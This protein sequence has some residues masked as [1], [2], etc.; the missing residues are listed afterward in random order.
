MIEFSALIKYNIIGY[1]RDIKSVIVRLLEVIM[2]TLIMGFALKDNFVAGNRTLEKFKVGVVIED[3]GKV[4][5][6]FL[7]Y[8]DNSD[9]KD[10]IEL[11]TF[12][13]M[14][15]AKQQLGRS[16]IKNII[17]ITDNYS[18]N[19]L[20]EIK[21]ITERERSYY[22]N[23]VNQLIC[24]FNKYEEMNLIENKVT[25]TNIG[26]I[27][28]LDIK[29]VTA[30]GRVPKSMDFYG[31]TMLV[32]F[33]LSS[34]RQG[35][36]AYSRVKKTPLGERKRIAPI[37]RGIDILASIVA[38]FILGTFEWVL[39]VVL[40]KYSLGVNYGNN[41]FVF[42]GLCS[43][44]SI[45]SIF[46]GII[47]GEIVGNYG[48]AQSILQLFVYMSTFLAGGFSGGSVINSANALVNKICSM[49]PNVF[50]HSILFSYIYLGDKGV[51]I[52]SLWSMVM[53]IVALTLI[54]VLVRKRRRE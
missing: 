11:I 37:N 49:L 47:V 2:I 33:I 29:H 30:T 44:L 12:S 19:I 6:E 52:N 34:S 18:Y 48:K 35:C 26:K 5:G 13:N 3:K 24:S 42:M 21:L 36:R 39:F 41:L 38:Q 23:I 53:E 1:F 14:G 54:A 31:V 32:M 28:S 43:I 7:K 16:E 17:Y 15:E 22:D 50:G 27:K 9:V 20:K 8:I 4:S 46:F 25:E 40:C 45:F 51:I 10:Y